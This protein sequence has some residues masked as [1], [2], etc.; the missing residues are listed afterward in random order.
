MFICGNSH[1]IIISTFTDEPTIIYLKQQSTIGNYKLLEHTPQSPKEKIKVACLSVDKMKFIVGFSGGV[2]RVYSISNPNSISL[3]AESVNVHTNDI[4]SIDVHPIRPDLAVT[5]G[6]DGQTIIWRIDTLTPLLYFTRDDYSDKNLRSLLLLEVEFSPD[7]DYLSVS[8]D[9]GSF[10]LFGIGS[11]SKNSFQWTPSQQFYST[12]YKKLIYDANGYC[13]DEEFHVPPHEVDHGP[14]CDFY[15]NPY[16]S[17]AQYHRM[18]NNGLLQCVENRYTPETYAYRTIPME[19]APVIIEVND[20]EQPM[21]EDNPEDNDEVVYINDDE[22]QP[23]RPITHLTRNAAIRLGVTPVI[24]E[25]VEMGQRQIINDISSSELSDSST[26]HSSEYDDSDLESEE[27]RSNEINNNSEENAQPMDIDESDG[28]NHRSLLQRA[29]NEVE[30]SYQELLKEVSTAFPHWIHRISRRIF[31]GT[32]KNITGNDNTLYVESNELIEGQIIGLRLHYDH[33]SNEMYTSIDIKLT[34]SGNVMN[35][36]VFTQTKIEFVFLAEAFQ[37][38]IAYINRERRLHY[39]GGS[40]RLN[41]TS[42]EPLQYNGISLLSSNGNVNVSIYEIE[43]DYIYHRDHESFSDEVHNH[44]LNKIQEVI[45]NP[46]YDIFVVPVDVRMYPNYLPVCPFPIDLTTILIRLRNDEY[47]HKYPHV[48]FEIFKIIRNAVTFNDP[49]SQIGQTAIKLAN[50]FVDIFT[51][52]RNYVSFDYFIDL[53]E[54][55]T[56]FQQPR[57]LPQTTRS[58]SRRQTRSKM[59]I[60][61]TSLIDNNESKSLTDEDQSSSSTKRN[62]TKVFVQINNN[63]VDS[64]ESSSLVSS[65]ESND[66]QLESKNQNSGSESNEVYNPEVQSDDDD[67]EEETVITLPTHRFRRN[68]RRKTIR[69][70]I[71]EV[72]IDEDEDEDDDELQQETSDETPVIP[73]RYK[74]KTRSSFPADEPPAQRR[75]D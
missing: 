14:L 54:Q 73:N 74:R 72:S 16:I 70:Q 23:T 75:K 17:P 60:E 59:E 32:S 1:K 40:Y 63:S 8:D 38:A 41:N 55:I 69:E 47:Y 10:S 24:E 48:E 52:C 20:Q 37:Y 22:N 68:T 44:L 12:D 35:N 39:N 61:T 34:R 21:V 9:F 56:S 33:R 15:T 49:F 57:V 67:D 65:E 66:A 6:S 27:R 43:T 64:D 19:P 4:L 25:Q 5:A 26:L 18:N 13:I 36:V 31:K 11:E 28:N 58:R 29:Q 51:E 3:L 50:E 53:N 62:L 7:G 45:N 42:F 30:D 46:I 71:N 2:V